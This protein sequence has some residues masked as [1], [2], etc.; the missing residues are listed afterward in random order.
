MVT[1][2]TFN[3]YR[4]KTKDVTFLVATNDPKDIYTYYGLLDVLSIER[5]LEPVV[6]LSDGKYNDMPV[7][8]AVFD[9][10]NNVVLDL[11]KNNIEVWNNALDRIVDNIKYED[12]ITN[13]VKCL[14][15]SIVDRNRK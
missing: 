6:I 9:D 11:N 3:Y 12:T 14:I 10:T 15:D 2:R 5:L 8:G 1:E 13:S 7:I 4:V